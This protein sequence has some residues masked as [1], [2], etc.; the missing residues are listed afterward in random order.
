[1]AGEHCLDLAPQVSILAAPRGDK[2]CT[3]GL[4][5]RQRRVKDPGDLP[6]PFRRHRAT[7]SIVSTAT[8]A[9]H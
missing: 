9:R 7:L 2:R 5:A 3:F 8:P 4:V 6:P 1:M